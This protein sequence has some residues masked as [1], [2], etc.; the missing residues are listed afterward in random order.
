MK[1]L[2]SLILAV[3]FITGFAGAEIYIKQKTHTDPVSMMGQAQ[4]A[5]DD[6]QETWIGKNRYAMHGPE[7]SSIIDLDK[8]ILYF[9]NH[10]NKTYIPMTL[11]VN[12]DDYMPEQMAAMMSSMMGSI[13][14]K[15]TPLGQKKTIGRWSAEG[16]NVDMDVMMMKMKMTVWATKDVPFDWKDF[17]QNMMANM[18]KTQMRLSDEAAQEFMKI[19]GYNIASETKMEMMG[20]TIR[21]T[22]EVVEIS[23]KSAGA[24]IF[25]PPADYTKQDKFTMEDMRR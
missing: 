15:V 20:S 11:P 5:K 7:N 10:Q 13:K 4:P 12:L 2:C 21:T 25:Q 18:L 8:K 23:E 19:N 16:Y 17:N 22:T 3:A 1:K 24:G 14:V 6:I 9:V